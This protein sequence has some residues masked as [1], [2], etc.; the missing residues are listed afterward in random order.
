MSSLC[1]GSQGTFSLSQ[2]IFCNVTFDKLFNLPGRFFIF[3]RDIGMVLI[4]L[5]CEA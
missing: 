1:I 2:T 5:K 4:R 3:K